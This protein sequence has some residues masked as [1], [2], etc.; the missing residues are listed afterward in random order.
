MVVFLQL[1]LTVTVAAAAH[2]VYKCSLVELVFFLSKGQQQGVRVIKHTHTLTL[3]YI[4]M[5]LKSANLA[6]SVKQIH[7]NLLN[8]LFLLSCLSR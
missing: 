7:Q 6:Q 8:T 5:T 3:I 2:V 4:H 1:M